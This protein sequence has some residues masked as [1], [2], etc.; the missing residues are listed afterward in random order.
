MT[1]LV[2]ESPWGYGDLDVISELSGLSLL[3]KYLMIEMEIYDLL[4]KSAFSNG[5][6]T[7]T[8]TR[9]FMWKATA[10][11]V[12]GVL[13]LFADA[14]FNQFADYTEPAWYSSSYTVGINMKPGKIYLYEN[15]NVSESVFLELCN[16]CINIIL[17]ICG[18]VIDAT[19]LT[20]ENRESYEQIAFNKLSMLSDTEYK[21]ITFD[22]LLHNF[23]I[24]STMIQRS[25][26]T[27]MRILAKL[28]VGFI[29]IFKKN[30]SEV[31][32]YYFKTM[33]SGLASLNGSNL[34]TSIHNTS[35]LLM[36]LFAEKWDALAAIYMSI[37]YTNYYE[38]STLIGYEDPTIEMNHFFSIAKRYLTAIRAKYR[39]PVERAFVSVPNPYNTFD[40]CDF[41]GVYLKPPIPMVIPSQEPVVQLTVEVANTKHFNDVVTR[42]IHEIN[43][44][45]YRDTPSIFVPAPSGSWVRYAFS[46]T[47]RSSV[48]AVFTFTN[49]TH[50]EPNPPR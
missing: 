10:R 43:V 39:P 17:S 25:R 47:T 44:N 23:T 5:Y 32:N 30:R 20:F 38:G 29:Y 50:D 31:L 1:E 16:R 35:D 11:P 24:T 14:I 33:H 7:D 41:G 9:D 28:F 45:T 15:R 6:S 12:G 4:N 2:V 22:M 48:W 21:K 18:N 46:T 19:N 13:S 27:F 37:L 34:P 3:E 8:V 49:S 36:S 26:L 40:M 42:T